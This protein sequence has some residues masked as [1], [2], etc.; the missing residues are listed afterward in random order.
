MLDC[1]LVAGSFRPQT[2]WISYWVW[3]VVP[4]APNGIQMMGLFV[5]G[6]LNLWAALGNNLCLCLRPSP[7]YW[8][9][10]PNCMSFSG[11]WPLS[12]T[13]MPGFSLSTSWLRYALAC[14]GGSSLFNDPGRLVR[15]ILNG[16]CAKKGLCWIFRIEIMPPTRCLY[17]F[18][19]AIFIVVKLSFIRAA[20]GA[21]TD[22]FFKC[23]CPKED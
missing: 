7:S 19:G 8:T 22:F 6:C 3:S 21:K 15:A 11:Y 12:E 23:L 17:W 1:L 9:I 5:F 13:C 16:C 18:D 14:L 2:F 10:G 20:E 4:P